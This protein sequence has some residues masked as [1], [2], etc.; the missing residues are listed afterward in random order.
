MSLGALFFTI[1]KEFLHLPCN[2]DALITSYEFRIL[3][4]KHG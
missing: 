3:K 1:A 4:F 2:N